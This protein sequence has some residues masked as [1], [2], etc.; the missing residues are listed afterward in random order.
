MRNQKIN[1]IQNC[2]RSYVIKLLALKP[3]G[4]YILKTFL[5]DEK[6]PCIPGLFHDNKFVIVDFK[7]K[8]ELF[9]LC[10]T[11]QCLLP[12]KLPKNLLFLTEK[13]VSNVQISNEN[14]IKIINNLDPN[15]AHGHK[16]ISIRM[17]KLCSPYLCK[18]LSII[19]KSWLSQVKFPMESEKVNVVPS[20]RHHPPSPPQK[21]MKINN[22]SNTTDLSLCFR[23]AVRSFKDFYLT[24]CTSYL[25]KM[26]YYHPTSQVLSPTKYINLLIMMS[27]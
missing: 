2:L 10:F 17:L 24:N 23:S 4:Q 1:I 6:I 18:S 27:R 15:K 19:F 13:C 12:K 16:M 21:K 25:M 9:N 20:P 5:N 11:E 22:A 26:N 14:I 3:T 7:E 8:T